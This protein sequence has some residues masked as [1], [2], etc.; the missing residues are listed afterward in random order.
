MTTTVFT[1]THFRHSN[2]Q[3][4]HT[5][6]ACRLENSLIGDLPKSACILSSIRFQPAGTS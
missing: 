4:N 5:A 3:L 2:I 1:L 6:A